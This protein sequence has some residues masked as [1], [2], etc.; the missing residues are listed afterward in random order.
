MEPG[1]D[2]FGQ[3]S[4]TASGYVQSFHSSS[5]HGIHHKRTCECLIKIGVQVF[6]KTMKDITHFSMCACFTTSCK[7]DFF[8]GKFDIL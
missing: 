3:V 2:S 8:G 4:G 5:F 6:K 1:N 7:T